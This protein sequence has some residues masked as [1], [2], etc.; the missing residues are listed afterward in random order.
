MTVVITFLPQIM[1]WAESTYRIGYVHHNVASLKLPSDWQETAAE[2]PVPAYWYHAASRFGLETIAWGGLRA[3][4]GPQVD[5]ATGKITQSDDKNA[6]TFQAGYTRDNGG[7]MQCGLVRYRLA[8][9]NQTSDPL[10][11]ILNSQLTLY[12]NT[13]KHRY[14]WDEGWRVLE[15]DVV[16]GDARFIVWN[17][18]RAEEP[19]HVTGMMLGMDHKEAAH[20]DACGVSKILESLEVER[21]DGSIWPASGLNTKSN[22]EMTPVTGLL[23]QIEQERLRLLGIDEPAFFSWLEKSLNDPKIEWSREAALALPYQQSTSG[24]VRLA[25][26]ANVKHFGEPDAQAQKYLRLTLVELSTRC[27][28]QDHDLQV[29]REIYDSTP[30]LTVSLKPQ[31]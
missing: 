23:V 21:P 29:I 3:V 4:P 12:D 22:P 17:W 14:I 7:L 28:L 1:I 11:Q 24:R 26:L 25:D 5:A 31:C 15:L 9:P 16:V 18:W 19:N 13:F 6:F 10:R 8:F 27:R 30:S 2:E 20:N